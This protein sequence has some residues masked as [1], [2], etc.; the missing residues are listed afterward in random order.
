MPISLKEFFEENPDIEIVIYAGKGGLGKTTFSAATAYW[1]AKNGKKVLCF[2]TDPQASLSDI[3][4][5]DLFG[6]GEQEI[7]EN[8]FVVEIDADKE[9]REY[10]EEIRRKIKEMYRME[11][12]PPE[13][14]E[15]IKSAAAEPAMHECA[16]YDAMAELVASGRYDLYVFDMPPF[17]HGV[18]MISMAQILD[19]WID[20][21]D[22][23]RRKA[24]E[25]TQ[26]VQALKGSTIAESE[27]AILNELSE[28]RRKLDTFR[29]ILIDP[30]RTAF[31]MVLIPEKMAILDTK[32]ALEMFNKLG[33]KLSGI[34]VNQV[35]PPELLD[36]PD[37]G[38]F[39]RNRIQM[40]QQY[41]KIIWDEF[42][43]YIRA[44][45]PMFDREPKGLD[46]IAKVAEHIFEKPWMGRERFEELVR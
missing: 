29:D 22:E 46:M 32:R 15:Y 4:E 42:G 39:L 9:I 36:R 31:F 3:F 16:T 41:M 33:I 25:Y 18:R 6:K 43:D 38:E 5:R 24:A 1:M 19:A 27:D 23:T 2:S 11:E 37:V 21:I 17:G 35:Y 34:L 8:L 10:Q 7:I 26:M 13:I 30:H 20:K 12:I 14:D 40:Q 45:C 28:I 44:V